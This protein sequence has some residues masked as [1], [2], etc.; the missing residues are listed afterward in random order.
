MNQPATD[1][2]C[3]REP[4]SEIADAARLLDAA[5]SA[6][7]MGRHDL[8]EE[9]IRL[10]DMPAITDFGESLWGTKSP[11]TSNIETSQIQL[12]NASCGARV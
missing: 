12:G 3:L 10:A 7:L 9:L 2:S 8:A 1:R 11:P 4:I 5:V 6:H